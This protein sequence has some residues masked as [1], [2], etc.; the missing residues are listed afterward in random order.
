MEVAIAEPRNEAAL[1]AV[2]GMGPRLLKKYGKDIL[3]LVEN[4]QR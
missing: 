2:K 4:P 1:L 3:A